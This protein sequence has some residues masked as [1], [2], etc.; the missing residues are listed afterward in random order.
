MIY[1]LD[2]VMYLHVRFLM[3]PFAAAV[4]RAGVVPIGQNVSDKLFVTKDYG[5]T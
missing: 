2:T 5:R 1:S 4:P 3:E